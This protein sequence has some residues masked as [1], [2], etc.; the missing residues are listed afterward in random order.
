MRTAVIGDGGQSS[1]RHL[2][3]DE[4]AKSEQK[5]GRWRRRDRFAGPLPGRSRRSAMTNGTGSPENCPVVAKSG[6]NRTVVTKP[7]RPLRCT[8]PHRRGGAPVA[9]LP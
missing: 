6:S 3:S 1:R 2:R 9:I 4:A 5:A 8:V 7:D